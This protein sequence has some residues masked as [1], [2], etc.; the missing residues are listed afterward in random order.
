MG[1]VWIKE[2]TGGLDTRRMPETTAGGV[3]IQAND[4]HVTRGG[5][6]EKRAAFVP[7]YNLPGDL[8]TGLARTPDTLVV[9]GS[10]TTPSLPSGVI[11]QRLQHADGVTALSRVLSWDIFAR[12]LYVA[13]LFA[14]GTVYHFYDGTRVTD[15]A[16]GKARSSFDV[17][18]GTGSSTLTALTVNGVEI[19]GSTITWTTSN[20]NT[21]TLIAAQI[22]TFVSSPEYTAVSNGTTV[23][24]IAPTAGTASNGFAVVST[25]AGGLVLSPATG[26]ILSGGVQPA[27]LVSPGKFVRTYGSRELTLSET[28]IYGSGIQQPTKWN[29]DTVG[30]FFI[31]MAT[32]SSDINELIAVAEYQSLV[33]IFAEKVILI[34]YFDSDPANNRKSQVLRNTG[35][36][37]AKSVTQFGDNDL[38]YLDESGVRSLRARDAS[39]AAATSDI[40]VP[41]DTI[42]SAK[43]RTLTDDERTMVIGLIEP[44]D[45]RFWLIMKDTIYVFSFFPGSKVSAWS[46][47]TPGFNISDGVVFDR[48]IYV[49]SGETIYVYGGPGDNLVYDNVSAVA[50]LPYLDGGAPSVKKMFTG[51]DAA[52]EGQ[53]DVYASLDPN[54]PEAEDLIATIYETTYTQRAI[55]AMG[56]TT[57]L[58][59]TFRSRNDSAAKLGSALVHYTGEPPD[60][61]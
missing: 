2:F 54:N 28:I 12:K 11:Y 51:A 24:I 37:S 21:A 34:W 52:V 1:T 3:L 25:V 16:D 20:T 17:T 15:W 7:A 29:T 38:F 26:G 30:A 14:D 33:A 44:R 61:D 49:R 27:D 6:F 4:G 9:F 57:H 45:G 5:E 32:Q 56:E 22:N 48:H 36:A 53:W 19:L 8:T 23:T 41:V 13:A 40:G 50:Q 47:Y 39:N 55:P 59:M 35:T 18:G 58:S 31:D 60:E 43:L 42:V 46:T 10:G